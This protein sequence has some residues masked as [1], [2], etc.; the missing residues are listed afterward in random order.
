MSTFRH[1]KGDPKGADKMMARMKLIVAI[2]RF[3]KDG[4]TLQEIE[5][6]LYHQIEYEAEEHGVIDRDLIEMH[7]LVLGLI[8]A[9]EATGGKEDDTGEFG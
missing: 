3:M 1:P 7:D 6:V 2:D 8:R 4:H 5:N 9:D